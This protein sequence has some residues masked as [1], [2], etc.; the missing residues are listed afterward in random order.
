M[1]MYTYND[2]AYLEASYAC[3][4][5]SVIPVNIN[6]RYKEQELLYLFDNSDAQ[7][8]LIH[9]DF[10]PSLNKI[11]PQLDK[12]KGVIIIGDAEIDSKFS[13]ITVINYRDLLARKSSAIAAKDQARSGDDKIIIYTG[14]TTGLPKGVMWRQRD[15]YRT[16]A[17]GTDSAPPETYPLYHEFVSN[18][19]K[20]LKVLILPPLMHGTAF[21]SSLV[22]LLAGG[23]VI[24]AS[25]TRVFDAREVLEI[26]EDRRPNAM[27]IVG[28]AFGQPLL[29][30]LERKNYDI[31]SIEFIAS[32]GA[33][34]SHR[35]KSG[36]LMHNKSMLLSDGLGS[37]EAHNIGS[38]I[39][40]MDNIDEL[41][42]RFSFNHNTLLLDDQMKP[43]EIKPGVKG[44][45][46]VSGS[47]PAG[48]YK[49]ER[50]SKETFLRI[51]GLECTPSGDWVQVN[52]DGITFSLLGRGS[53]CINTG[54]EKVFPEEVEMVIK[55]FGGIVD[56]VV[57]G[58]PDDKW[59]EVVTA[60]ISTDGE[61]L[62]REALVCFVRSK[63]ANYKAPKNIVIVPRVFRGPNGKADYKLTK[64]IALTEL[65]GG[66]ATT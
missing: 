34:W 46:A 54:G 16:L 15:L 60:V 41:T 51:N 3:I 65:N 64:E 9:S 29:K 2:I 30:E 56:A 32:A 53:A 38:S 17:G 27:S 66:T 59:G 42:P 45:I 11:L 57:V 13:H 58:I 24:L 22:V 55:Q 50:K 31:S 61:E 52:E 8:V 26:V 28:D 14:G 1:A 25:N 23:S 7:I 63:L 49:D 43:I 6:Y 19:P 62:G 48:Y 36:L 37:S 18:T 33:I 47:R 5:T 44:M 35:V 12:I 10:V 40:T 20:I 39:T 21:F 4:K